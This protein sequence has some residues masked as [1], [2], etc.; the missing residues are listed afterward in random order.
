MGNIKKFSKFISESRDI[1]ITVPK[2]VKWEDYENELRAAEEGQI[3]N[4]K[5]PN[6]PDVA[7]GSKCYI[8]YDGNIVGYHIVSGVSRKKFECTTSGKQW[9]D[10]WYIE[11]TG[12]FNK[13]EPIPM[14]GFQ[15]YRYV[16]K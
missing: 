13:I 10:A 6:K 3:L 11:R 1:I 2:S 14:K 8:V 7:K 4:F 16:K 5:V 15:G 9:E 12:K